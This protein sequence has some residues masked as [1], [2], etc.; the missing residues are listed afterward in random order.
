[1]LFWISLG[2]AGAATL[3]F[4][5]VLAFAAVVA[6]FASALALTRIL[7]FAGVLT[8]VGISQST[9]RRSGLAL[10]T[11]GVRL[12]CQRSAQQ[13]GDSCAGDHRF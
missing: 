7:A 3:A 9:D 8:L 2:F 13:T 1:M 4:A 12:Y 10:D 6:S 5:R 11:G